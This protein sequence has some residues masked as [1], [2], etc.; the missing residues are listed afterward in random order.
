M[1]TPALLLFVSGAS[2]LI[3]QV[4]WIKQLSLVV[5]VEIYA[6][7]VAISAFFAGLALGG[8]VLGPLADRAIRPLRFYAAV[9]GGVAVLAVLATVGL[10][11]AASVF[12]R[13][14]DASPFIAWGM[15]FALVGLPSFLMG[16][17]LPAIVRF[18]A[19]GSTR[20]GQAGGRLYAANTAGGI[21]GA[22][23]PP[24]SLIPAL[25][26]QGT[27]LFA[28]ALNLS[29]AGTALAL[30]AFGGPAAPAKAAQAPMRYSPGARIALT[31]Y[32]VAGGVALG[33][34]A[35]WS[36]ILVQF[37]STRAFAFSVV[38]AVY[39]FGIALGAAI[40]ARWGNRARDPWLAFGLL[41]A[42][43]A[44]VALAE[45][46][47]LGHWLAYAQ[48]F[49]EAKIYDLTASAFA[50]MCARF[51][52]AGLSVVFLPTLF[53]GAAFPA[54]LRLIVDPD[55]VGGGVG[56]VA[57]LNT[58]AGIAGTL[59]TG[60]VLIPAFGLVHALAL[61][62]FMGSAVGLC[63]VL[64]GK[65]NT[66]VWRWAVPVVALATLLVAV[67]TPAD[68]L[69][70]LFPGV[71]SGK[72]VFY[73]EGAGGTVAVVEHQG[74]RR[75]F[76]QG[77]SN[78]GDAMPSLRYMRL[79]ALLPLIIHAADPKSALVVG[80]GTGITAGALTQFPGLGKPVVAELLPAVVAA[81]PKFQGTF[82]NGA[83]LDIRLRDGRRELQASAER[84]DLITLEPPP[85]SATG[86]VNLYS[87][88]FY[89]LAGARLNDKGIVAQWLPLAT[90]NA[91]DTKSLVK[92]FINVFPYAYLW[93]TEVHEMLLVGSF[94]PMPLDMTRIAARF[95]QP[96]TAAAL[97]EVGI[98][99][100][101]ALLATFVTDRDGLAH[102]AFEAPP[103]TD[104]Q[105]RIEYGAW[106][107][108]GE[109]GPVLGDLAQYRID[110]P[111]VGAEPQ[112]Q[113]A[114]QRERDLLDIFYNA[115]LSAYSG[116]RDSWERDARLI[117]QNAPDNAYY[118]WFLGSGRQ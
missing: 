3:F 4:L 102:F 87:S 89:R 85:P 50:G 48:T 36:Q 82:G 13:F 106:V 34:E 35:V 92:S 86:V 98:A 117:A 7:T 41:I 54:A 69:V 65:T 64:Y 101:A 21:V 61:L 109:L 29:A 68:R 28:A 51:A 8:I 67:N 39:L 46:A 83:G 52:V 93:T 62:A 114:F 76:I 79:Q 6:I 112:F 90:Q 17:T 81:A 97:S 60:F 74:F 53:L 19:A 1:V 118:R 80:Y 63:A 33:Y 14:E 2:A 113:I 75:L 15:V 18:V 110:P 91:D 73:Q 22:L 71:R 70:H 88:D 96:Q 95:S 58:A 44:L 25:G 38:L 9:E 23:L 84:Y 103:V 12:A 56:L 5:G 31:L 78:S 16:G 116:D 59:L 115:A 49:A 32:T 57:G 72:L 66:P 47:L 27:A 10:P 42:A 55:H 11:R 26:M 37:T 30:D 43:A 104:D 24:F 45:I 108:P 107:R 99:S 77:V 111:L 94:Q 100:P 20:V 105:P 40:F